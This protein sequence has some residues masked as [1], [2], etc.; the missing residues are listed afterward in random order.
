M[1]SQQNNSVLVTGRRGFIGRA[2]VKLLQRSDIPV[3]SLDRNPAVAAS[4]GEHEVQCDL[5]DAGQLHEVFARE[6]ITGVIHLAAILPTAAQR[7][8]FLATQVNVLGSLNLLEKAREFG[9]R[10]FV[11]GSSLSVYGTY[12][13]DRVIS[14]SDKAA[15][16]D[17][18]GAAKLYIEQAGQAYRECHG[19]DFVSLRI[20]RVVGPG[21]NSI[22]SAW[23]SEI[24]ELLKASYPVQ[25]V[26]PY[27]ATENILVV[28]LEDLGTMLLAVL[29]ARR[30]EYAVYN[31]PCRSVVVGDLKHVVEN[32][33]SN[34]TVDLGDGTPSALRD[35]WIT[36]GSSVNLQSSPYRFSID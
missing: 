24:F 20:G 8:P 15:P 32:L 22:S 5:S 35:R 25:I 30:T 28:H 27:L 26:V 10:R 31:S 19:L 33:N 14:E 29:R 36:L 17:L 23:R 3:I 4:D 9:I 13:A 18:Y 7:N 34:I 1:Q 16:E 21:A 2:V 12:S 11:F 6:R